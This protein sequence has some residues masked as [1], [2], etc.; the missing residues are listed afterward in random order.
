MRRSLAIAFGSIFVATFAPLERRAGVAGVGL[1]ERNP[2]SLPPQQDWS[3]AVAGL[4]GFLDEG[5]RETPDTEVCAA[6]EREIWPDRE[7]PAWAEPQPSA[8]SAEKSPSLRRRE[9]ESCCLHGT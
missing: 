6:C 7:R 2:R 4:S 5:L 1:A 9:G 8:R 3:L